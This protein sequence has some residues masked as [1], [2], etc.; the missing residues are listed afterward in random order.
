MALVAWAAV[1]LKNAKS[2]MVS[3]RLETLIKNGPL[4]GG[5]EILFILE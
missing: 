5:S 3:P 4:I 2:G 1:Y